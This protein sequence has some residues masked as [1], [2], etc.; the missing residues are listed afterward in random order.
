[1]IKKRLRI[2][3]VAPV[4]EPVPPPGYGGTELFV[5]NLV[6]GL[7]RKGHDVTCLASGDSYI[8]GATM[9][10]CSTSSTRTY[11][12]ANTWSKRRKL[13][14]DGAK[15]AFD[16]LAQY[17]D[18]FDVIINNN[19]W[20]ML[21]M[22]QFHPQMLQR[23]VTVLHG[24][25]YNKR[26]SAKYNLY[27]GPMFKYISISDSQRRPMPHLNYVATVHHGIDVAKFDYQPYPKN[28]L[29]WLGRYTPDMGPLQAI[30]I[31]KKLDVVL[32]MAGKVDQADEQYFTDYVAP[33]A[34]DPGLTIGSEVAHAQKVRLLKNANALLLPLQWHEP[35]GLVMIES[36]ACGTPV[37]VFT[38]G[39]APEI[40]EDGKTG[41]LCKNEREAVARI[42]AGELAAI[43][44]SYCRQVAQ[45][46]FD[47]MGMVSRYEQICNDL[48][49]NGVRL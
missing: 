3:V 16:Y 7:I 1:M 28:Y 46:R 49:L 22:A 11:S 48:S 9:V 12:G 13:W 14:L 36:L 6:N 19:G 10:A 18:Q 15:K 27:S 5:Y 33:H 26:E 37:V 24:T 4:D 40:I 8:R 31:A 35:F 45:S 2:A 17:H 29:A 39:S 43:D 34:F 47:Y 23:M 30:R 41:L 38:K 32:H 21:Q 25:L 44:R 42:K 20:Q